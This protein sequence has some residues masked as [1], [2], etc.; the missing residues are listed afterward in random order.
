MSYLVILSYTSFSWFCFYPHDYSFST[1]LLLP[2]ALT[3]IHAV[4]DYIAKPFHENWRQSYLFL[5]KALKPGYHDANYASQT[6][7]LCPRVWQSHNIDCIATNLSVLVLITLLPDD[8]GHIYSYAAQTW[9]VTIRVH[10]ANHAPFY[11]TSVRA[12]GCSSF[13]GS[14]IA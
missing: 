12:A 7:S 14:N 8:F 10:A 2:L 6:A 5:S 1:V 11:R 9:Q 3:E 13:Y 4:C